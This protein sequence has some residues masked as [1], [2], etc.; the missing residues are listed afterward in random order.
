V[1]GH[2]SGLLVYGEQRSVAAADFDRDGRTDL[3][4]TQNGAQVKLYRN[5]YSDEPSR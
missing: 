5:Q 4:I 2:E 1:P 3:V